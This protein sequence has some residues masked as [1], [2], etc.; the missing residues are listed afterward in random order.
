MKYLR[1]YKLFESNEKLGIYS[2]YKKLKSDVM[3]KANNDIEDI[4]TQHRPKFIKYIEMCLH[5]FGDMFLG[6]VSGSKNLHLNKVFHIYHQTDDEIRVKFRTGASSKR[7]KGMGLTDSW[8]HEV[9]KLNDLHTEDIATIVRLIM[10]SDPMKKF[11]ASIMLKLNKE[12]KVNNFLDF[13]SDSI[14]ENNNDDIGVWKEYSLEISVA[15]FFKRWFPNKKHIGTEGDYDLYSYHH[16]DYDE[17]EDEIFWETKGTLKVD[18]RKTD[19]IHYFDKVDV[20]RG[21][22]RIRD[23]KMTREQE[24]RVRSWCGT[25]RNPKRNGKYIGLEKGLVIFKSFLSDRVNGKTYHVLPD[26]EVIE[27]MDVEDDGVNK[28]YLQEVTDY[29]LDTGNYDLMHHL[30]KHRK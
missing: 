24:L 26:G 2:D 1:K 18:K 8:Q 11:S 21:L 3:D 13:T 25:E 4:D 10:L 28:D 22:Y 17:D 19:T 15:D 9:M 20:S 5:K 6:K 16:K 12:S 29:L 7:Y 23:P 27:M 14:N 30:D